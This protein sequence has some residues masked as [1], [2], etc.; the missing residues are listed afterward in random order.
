MRA[1]PW[2]SVQVPRAS[3]PLGRVGW[4]GG[5][6]LTQE[7]L[8]RSLRGVSPRTANYHHAGYPE[9]PGPGGRSPSEKLGPSG[10]GSQA[11]QTA[12]GM[13]LGPLTEGAECRGLQPSSD[14]T[15]RVHGFLSFPF[16]K[17]RALTS[18]GCRGDTAKQ[19]APHCPR[20]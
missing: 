12:Q 7:A 18:P 13:G 1:Q 3:R 8:A 10:P 2:F 14:H 15:G 4:E 20:G 6:A 17:M 9:C 19:A 11:V 16:C 5:Q